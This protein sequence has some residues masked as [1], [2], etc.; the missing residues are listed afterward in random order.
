MR[1]VKGEGARTMAGAEPVK[2][3]VEVDQL[4]WLAR[5]LDIYMMSEHLR[6]EE[7][8]GKLSGLELLAFPEGSVI[9]QE[10]SPGRDLFVLFNGNAAVT[11]A[12]KPVAQLTPG[13][14][15]GEIGFLVGVPRTA[16]VSAGPDCEAFRCE[17]RA[18]EEILSEHPNL[19]DSMRTIAKL[20]MEKLQRPAGG[21]P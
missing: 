21:N 9:V 14:L 6:P 7:L 12:G 20:R 18:F 3:T 16:T 4:N 5:A 15:F 17:A 13:D 11:R 2:K 19:L 1:S 8:I 10:G